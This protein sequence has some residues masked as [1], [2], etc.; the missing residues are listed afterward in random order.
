MLR[1]KP[2]FS[3]DFWKNASVVDARLLEAAPRYIIFIG[4]R[5]M[6]NF[7]VNITFDLLTKLNLPYEKSHQYLQRSQCYS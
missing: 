7:H 6:G 5:T 2:N 3:I 1:G 4:K